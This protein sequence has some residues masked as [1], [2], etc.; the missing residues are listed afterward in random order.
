MGRMSSKHKRKKRKLVIKDANIAKTDWFFLG[1]TL[2][3][4][5]LGLLMVFNASVIQ[6]YTIFGDKFHFVKNQATWGVLAIVVMTIAT[7]TPISLIKKLATPL[8]IFSIILLILVLIPGMS[9]KVFGARRWLDLG[10]I[11]FQP[12]EL[13]KLSTIIYFPL[14]LSRHQRLE[15]FIAITS[16]TIALLLMEPDLGTSIIIAGI[17]FSLYYISGA[18]L[19]HLTLIALAGILIT[20]LLIVA[21]PYRRARLTTF[22]DPGQDPLGKSY[23]V[24]QVIIALGSGGWYGTGIGRSRQ[25]YQYLPEA[26]TDSIFAV[27]AE[28]LGFIG[29]LGLISL[30]I[31][32]VN[33]GLSTA[34]KIHQPYENLLAVAVIAW[35]ST[36]SILNLAA[37]VILVPLTGVPLPLVSYGGSSLITIMAAIGLYLNVSKYAIRT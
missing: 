5:M 3:L 23:H 14:W 17:A 31:I 6:A 19:K 21:S 28:E 10:F 20:S 7:V 11:T 8:F 27:F 30:I 12:S 4:L 13:L 2:V 36:Q 37:M 16:F 22:L 15:P 24:R 29:G 26:T 1:I 33:R 18:R 25:K 35:I 9:S 32:M 34:R